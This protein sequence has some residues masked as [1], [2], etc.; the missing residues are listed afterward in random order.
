MAD[1]NNQFIGKLTAQQNFI[2]KQHINI[3]GYAD[4][5]IQEEYCHLSD[6][7]DNTFHVQHD[8]L[9]TEQFQ[10][11]LTA[12]YETAGIITNGYTSQGINTS[13]SAGRYY[14]LKSFSSTSITA[15]DSSP[16]T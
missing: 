14:N 5:G 15:L 13:Y 10:D 6:Y 7:A 3:L 2:R 16:S 1:I 9:P 8:D 12:V 4:I 11:T